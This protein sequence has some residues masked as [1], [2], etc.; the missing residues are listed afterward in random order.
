[1]LQPVVVAEWP[2]ATTSNFEAF[3]HD[4]SPS[5]TF[6]S[7]RPDQSMTTSPLAREGLREQK[8][9]CFHDE[10]ERPRARRIT[11]NIAK[12]PGTAARSASGGD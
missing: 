10:K 11:A 4:L 2:I 12:V 7:H 9:G 5:P 8:H 3:H 6:V 1:M